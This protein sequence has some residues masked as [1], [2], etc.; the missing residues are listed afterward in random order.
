[1]SN[2]VLAEKKNVISRNE[3]LRFMGRPAQ[4]LYLGN[5]CELSNTNTTLKRKMKR[6]NAIKAKKEGEEK[7]N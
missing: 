5:E 2:D 7:E 4:L 1:V 6:I 3:T